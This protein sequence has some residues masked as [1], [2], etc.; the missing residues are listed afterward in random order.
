[1][2]VDIRNIYDNHGGHF[3]PI[4]EIP[5][6][7]HNLAHQQSGRLFN[8]CPL[9]SLT[10][11]PMEFVCLMVSL[12]IL[13]P[14]LVSWTKSHLLHS[15]WQ[16]TVESS[17]SE[18]LR[19]DPP[20]TLVPIRTF[21]SGLR[22]TPEVAPLRLTCKRRIDAKWPQA[23]SWQITPQSYEDH[24]KLEPG[25]NNEEWLKIA[26]TTWANTIWGCFVTNAL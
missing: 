18:T 7:A 17:P 20:S 25:G 2:A 16:V 22:Q 26:H 23:L 14:V 6:A 19:Q 10:S 24:S 12:S 1:M 21:L 4:A 5:L 11:S 13:A 9:T 3:S 15:G 8:R